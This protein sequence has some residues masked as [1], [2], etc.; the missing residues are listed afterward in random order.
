MQK[1]NNFGGKMARKKVLEGGTR[2]EIINAALTLFMEKGY[3]ETSVRMI[4]DEANAATGSFYHYFKSKEELFDETIKLY[5]ENYEKSF[6]SVAFDDTKTAIERLVLLMK[7]LDQWTKDFYYGNLQQK[8]LHWTMEYALRQITIEALIPGVQHLINAA[9]SEGIAKN[10]MNMDTSILA[11]IVLKGFEGILH[12]NP[13]QDLEPLE[14]VKVRETAIKYVMFVL[15]ISP[16]NLY[17]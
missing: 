15:H 8:K 1:M 14:I 6:T 5:L 12:A 4:L 9:L 11:V 13:I 7:N 17:A 3:E 16:E 2:D 10:I